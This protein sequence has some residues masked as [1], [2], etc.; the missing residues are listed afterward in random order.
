MSVSDRTSTVLAI[1]TWILTGTFGARA[2]QESLPPLQDAKVPTNLDALWG[3][4]DPRSEP[5]DVEILKEW[6]E[7][8]VVARIV[9]YTVGTF[10]GGTSK[11]AAFYSFPKGARKLP[12]LLHIHGGGQS[13]SLAGVVADA[14][15]GYA[16]L[17]INWGGNKMSISTSMDASGHWNGPQTDWGN[18]DATHPPQRSKV[19]HFVDAG[20]PDEYTLDPVA[21]PR[22]SNWFLVTIAA[23]RALTFLQLQAEVDPDV[24]GVQGHSMGGR[25]TTEVAAIDKRVKAAVPSCGGSGVITE[26]REDVPL[27]E[28]TKLA[29]EAV[30]TFTTNPYL[31]RIT[32][33]TLWYSSSNDFHG[34]IDSMAWNWRQ[35]PEHLL[36]FTIPP[37]YNH[38]S[39]PPHQVAAMLWF[40]SHLKGTVKL[41]KTPAM[42]VHLAAADGIPTV[43]VT[44]DVAQTPLG[45]EVYYSVDSHV[46]TRFWRCV[47]AEKSG[48][49]WQAKCPILSVNQPLFVFANVI[50]DTPE[51][52]R[53]QAFFP[54]GASN[55]PTYVLSSRPTL[56]GAAAL[57]TAGIKATDTRDR[58]IDACENDWADWYR[59]E[60]GNGH[61]WSLTTRKIKDPK[62]RAPAG[63]RLVFDVRCRTDNTVVVLASQNQW[64]VFPGKPTCDYLAAKRI[65]GSPE[66]QTVS[67]SLE[68][69]LPA[70]AGQVPLTS[71]EW[72]T[73]LG[74]RSRGTVFQNGKEIQFGQNTTWPS[75]R[76]FRNIRWEGGVYA[77]ASD[78]GGTLT[79]EEHH[80][81]FND[82]IQKSL[83]QEKLDR[84]AK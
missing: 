10:K 42:N 82:A 74:L 23:R 76:E 57:K 66:W 78:T 79:E 67:I 73:E 49:T 6:E 50:Y 45:V 71:W 1:L 41:P 19:N 81:G 26:K 16:S 2:G 3:S 59:L 8:G 27:G 83:D 64:G 17:S 20:I 80:K 60:W 44:P 51:K 43:V 46:L 70:K 69:M 36:A 25:L 77:T 72:I 40:E 5:L 13:A 65:N 14:L 38:R 55:S 21:S 35:V 11:V 32:C 48:G 4:Y 54:P 62:W 31:S 7:R 58:L 53:N 61:L 33:P 18:V 39:S 9:R 47:K 28:P 30:A 15:N 52:L 34:L 75:P 37:H 22:N 84:K 63:A 12:G 56:I 68:D 24:L 29:P